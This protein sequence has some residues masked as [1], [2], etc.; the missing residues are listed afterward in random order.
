MTES[1]RTGTPFCVVIPPT[2]VHVRA[3]FDRKHP[4]FVAL[5]H[6]QGVGGPI[7]GAWVLGG[8]CALAPVGQAM[9]S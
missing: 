4:S 9:P 6:V 5:T 1:P 3:V 8:A 7:I 2:S